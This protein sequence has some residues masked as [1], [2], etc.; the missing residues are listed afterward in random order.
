MNLPPSLVV[1]ELYGQ[2][3]ETLNYSYVLNIFLVSLCHVLRFFRGVK[4]KLSTLYCTAILAAPY[5]TVNTISLS[6][7]PLLYFAVMS[8]WCILARFVVRWVQLLTDGTMNA[9][10]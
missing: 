7:Y 10:L 6:M 2:L 1:K 5:L 3:M 9:E 8:Q 4:T